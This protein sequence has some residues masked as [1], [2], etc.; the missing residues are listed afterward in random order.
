MGDQLLALPAISGLKRSSPLMYFGR[1]TGMRLIRSLLGIECVDLDSARSLE[2]FDGSFRRRF[3]RIVCVGL[4]PFSPDGGDPPLVL[5]STKE[6]QARL[7]KW[8]EWVLELGLPDNGQFF[9][10]TRKDGELSLL[11]A[12]GSG[13]KKKNWPPE[14]YARLAG[15]VSPA[16][17]VRV[18]MGPCEMEYGLD[19]VWRNKG[20]PGEILKD[21]D[22]VRLM[23][24][25]ST[26][27]F[28]LG[29]DSGLS[30]L[31]GIFGLMGLV[32]FVS[33]DKAVWAPQGERLNIL[34]DLAGGP[35]FDS[36]EFVFTE[37]WGKYVG[38]TNS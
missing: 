5:L 22:E 1:S 33:S 27:P 14:N 13:G 25:F 23:E 28:F 6:S 11:I 9:R 19:E 15:A 38:W 34:G 24:L 32:I 29:N 37:Q 18:L 20:Y 2:L 12:P 7:S 4:P 26:G 10:K 17:R 21:P 8:K 16:A 31:A 36:V 3:E 30:H 35:S